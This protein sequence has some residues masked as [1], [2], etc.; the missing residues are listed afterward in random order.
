[1]MDAMNITLDIGDQGMHPR[2]DLR[3]PYARTGDEPFV[4]TGGIIQEAIA[5]PTIGLNHYFHQTFA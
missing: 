4:T 2:E 1:M 3:R 5:L